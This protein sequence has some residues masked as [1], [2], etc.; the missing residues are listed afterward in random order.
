LQTREYFIAAVQD[1]WDYVPVG[2]EMCGASNVSFSDAAKAFVERGPDRVGSKYIKALYREYNDATFTQR[3][4]REESLQYM[5][6]S[7]HPGS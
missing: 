3:K 6:A 7:R 5:E 4:V 2:G 1:E